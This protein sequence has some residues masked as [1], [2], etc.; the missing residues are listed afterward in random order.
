MSGQ[1][2]ISVATKNLWIFPT[3]KSLGSGQIDFAK[4][5]LDQPGCTTTEPQFAAH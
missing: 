4:P 2:G 5:N 3:V 1:V